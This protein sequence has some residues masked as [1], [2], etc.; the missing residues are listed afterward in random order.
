MPSARVE[1]NAT[2]MVR[3]IARTSRRLAKLKRLSLFKRPLPPSNTPRSTP[4]TSHP[5]RSTFALLRLSPLEL[6]LLAA[7]NLEMA[8]EYDEVAADARERASTRRTARTSCDER[9][10]R[11]A[12]F[13]AAAGR[14]SLLLLVSRHQGGQH[15]RS[16]YL[17]PER[18]AKTRRHGERRRT[19][20]AVRPSSSFDRRATADR[21]RTERRQ[22]HR[23]QY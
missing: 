3:L 8:S 2:E 14:F 9:R 16:V 19:A 1:R 4:I 6:A 13:H 12:R 22:T 10:A 15:L 18:R 11:A 23:R 5:S 17:G 20:S 7:L 21:R